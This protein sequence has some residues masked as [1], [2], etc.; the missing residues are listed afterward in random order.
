M[1]SSVP[2]SCRLFT[3][4]SAKK[5][6]NSDFLNV[7]TTNKSTVYSN[8]FFY[9]HWLPEQLT[10]GATRKASKK[11]DQ[12]YD[13]IVLSLL[14]DDV[15]CYVVYRLDSTNSQGYEWIFLA[16]SPDQSMV[17]K[18]LALMNSCPRYMVFSLLCS[19]YQTGGVYHI[20]AA[21]LCIRVRRKNW[22]HVGTST[23][24]LKI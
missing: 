2:E 3:A 6:L 5:T 9:T 17:R 23:R 24:P 12:E 8:T 15:P 16:W 19:E 14:E 4:S 11:W 7:Y 22:I 13:S 20:K 21:T 1:V 10:L 18:L